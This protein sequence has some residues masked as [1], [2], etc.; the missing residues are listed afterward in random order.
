M[1]TVYRIDEGNR[2]IGSWFKSRWRRIASTVTTLVA[3]PIVGAAVLIA[4][5]VLFPQEK[6]TTGL[7]VITEKYMNLWGDMFFD[8]W[9]KG[10]I[11]VF[12]N[13][14]NALALV[15]PAVQ[16]KV[17]KAIVEIASLAKYYEVM[18]SRNT[19][20][21]E[22][23]MAKS[24]ALIEA[25]NEFVKLYKA[26]LTDHNLTT[27]VMTR[28]VAVSIDNTLLT[29]GSWQGERGAVKVP[30]YGILNVIPGD[31]S[32]GSLPPFTLP[33]VQTTTVDIPDT[34]TQAPVSQ[35]SGSKPTEQESATTKSKYPLWL[36]IVAAVVTF[37]A[38][39]K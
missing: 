24:A 37:K 36:K 35:Q 7:S 13:V 14:T 34:S 2:G 26:V 27:S 5:N 4:L 17:N 28:S 33:P 31:P 16:S 25:G 20:D 39:T 11:A 29:D 19:V 15:T 18:A 23:L 12:K 32:G 6:S 22:L 38:L 1:K 21:R 10:K 30:Q 9:F 3:G 8:A